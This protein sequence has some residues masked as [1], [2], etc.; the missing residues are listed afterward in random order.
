M[1]TVK[2]IY[3]FLNSEIPFSTQMQW[4]NSGLLVGSADKEVHTIAV[5]LD[6]T[7]EN[8]RKALKNKVELIVCHHPVIFKAIKSVKSTDAV[9]QLVKNDVSLIA[10]HTP[11][12][13]ADD[14]VNYVLAN[15][16]GIKDVRPIFTES[17]GNLV[18]FGRIPGGISEQAF[19]TRVKEKLGIPFIKYVSANEYIKT[20]AVCG[21][22]G[23]DFID[24][25]AAK[26]DAFVTADVSYHEFLHAADMGLTLIDAGHFN[27]EDIS[28]NSLAVKIAVEF[29][30]VKV[31]RLKSK[32]PI[33]YR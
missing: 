25:V 18:R 30:G 32:D 1:T 28:M 23:A 20:V 21:G 15:A 14:G 3:E 19:C 16:L 33:S 29:S 4:D 5:M 8:I 17:A 24:D 9:Y 12:D 13:A 10:T 27:T 22:A 2:D 31:L 11:W 26:V 7:N 6:A